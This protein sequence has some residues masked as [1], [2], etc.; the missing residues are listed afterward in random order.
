MSALGSLLAVLAETGA[1]AGDGVLGELS[2]KDIVFLSLWVVLSV[3]YWNAYRASRDKESMFGS[4][5]KVGGLLGFVYLTISGF[6]WLAHQVPPEEAIT[7]GLGEAPSAVGPRVPLL[8]NAFTWAVG[9]LL[10][11][12]LWHARRKVGTVG[13]V[14][15]S[16]WDRGHWYMLPVIFIL[17]TVGL[18][19]VAA[20]ASPMLSPFIYTL[21]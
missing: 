15:L 17:L 6:D 13:G 19:L 5:L 3:A 9:L 14:I 16:A 4:L 1:A 2:T 11:L 21:F 18:L 12:V 10:V 20:A 7:F 8:A